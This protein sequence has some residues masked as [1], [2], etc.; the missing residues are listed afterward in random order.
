MYVCTCIQLSGTVKHDDFRSVDCVRLTE[1]SPDIFV[2][3]AQI[4]IA[5]YNIYRGAKSK[6]STL[7][8]L[9]SDLMVYTKVTEA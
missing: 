3:L 1:I 2:L 7:F 5:L 4:I 6:S 9:I 8:P